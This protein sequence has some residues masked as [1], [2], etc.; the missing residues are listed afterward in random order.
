MI[1]R[2]VLRVD[3]SA[4]FLCLKRKTGSGKLIFSVPFWAWDVGGMD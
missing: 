2:S 3:L 1:P 4:R